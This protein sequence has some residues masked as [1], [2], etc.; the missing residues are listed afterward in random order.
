MIFLLLFFFYCCLPFWHYNEY[1]GRETGHDLALLSTN[2]ELRKQTKNHSV[3]NGFCIMT[4]Y[5]FLLFFFWLAQC[6]TVR[7]WV[8]NK[9]ALKSINDEV[10]LPKIVRFMFWY[11]SMFNVFSEKYVWMSSAYIIRCHWIEK[12]KNIFR[13]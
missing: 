2:T 12:Y 7:V 8:W 6:S 1:F 5:S 10:L 9:R 4:L 11:L 13:I 3:Y